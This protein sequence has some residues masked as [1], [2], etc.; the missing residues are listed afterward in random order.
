[1]LSTIVVVVLILALIGAL[2][3]WPYSTSWGYAPGGLIGTVL[4]VVLILRLAWQNLRTD[5][6]VDYWPGDVWLAR[7]AFPRCIDCSTL[8]APV[9]RRPQVFFRRS[10][11][12]LGK[13]GVRKP[14]RCRNRYADSAAFNRILDASFE[15][16]IVPAEFREWQFEIMGRQDMLVRPAVTEQYGEIIMC[17]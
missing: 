1:M 12:C 9:R 17:A 5:S 11:A 2:P 7:P 16:F 4:V 3:A 14:E 8:T 10:C 6:T 13:A 15:I